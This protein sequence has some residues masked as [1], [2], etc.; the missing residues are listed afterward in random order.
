METKRNSL[1]AWILAARPKTLTGALIPV[2]TAAALALRHPDCKFGPIAICFIFASLMQTAANL[3]NDLFDYLKGTDNE[4]RLGPERA[5]AQGWITPKAMKKGIVAVLALALACGCLVLRYTTPWLVAVG[6]MCVCFAF[7]YTTILSYTGM[8]DVLVL[9]FFGIVPC[10]G[11]FFVA[12][13]EVTVQ[14]LLAS[15]ISGTVIDTLMIVNNYRD[16]DTDSRCGKKTVIVILGERF[17]RYFY[18]ACG[19][20]AWAACFAFLALNHGWLV[21][22][23]TL[24]LP[25]HI[26]TWKQMIAIGHG[27]ELNVSLGKTSRNILIFGVLLSVGLFLS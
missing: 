21:M 5:C 25:L 23:P 13:G 3:I 8:G 26:S 18:L 22:L 19:I 9:V 4:S 10:C 17:G 15:I 14:C 16:R 24:Y 2:M 20:A 1:R 6:A 7:L 27:R 12:T 11:T